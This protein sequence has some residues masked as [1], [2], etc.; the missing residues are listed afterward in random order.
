MPKKNETETQKQAKKA[1]SEKQKDAAAKNMT[2]ML[3]ATARAA[4]KRKELFDSI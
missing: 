2:G 3:G 1:A 4:R